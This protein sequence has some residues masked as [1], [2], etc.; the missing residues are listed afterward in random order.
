MLNLYVLR[1]IHWLLLVLG[2]RLYHWIVG[3]GKTAANRHPPPRQ[4][5]RDATHQHVLG[6][7]QKIPLVARAGAVLGYKR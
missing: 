4:H 1:N 2:N 5:H 6:E 7:D 3:V